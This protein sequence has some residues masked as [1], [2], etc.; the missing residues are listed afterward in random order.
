MLIFAKIA[1][2]V[3]ATVTSLMGIWQVAT[4]LELQPYLTLPSTLTYLNVFGLG[5]SNPSFGIE[6]IGNVSSELCLISMEDTDDNQ[7]IA[8]FG[9]GG[10]VP[11]SVIVEDPSSVASA[12]SHLCPPFD[13]PQILWAQSC[14][15]QDDPSCKNVGPGFDEETAYYGQLVLEKLASFNTIFDYLFS[16]VEERPTS[17]VEALQFSLVTVL[18]V[19]FVSVVGTAV[20]WSLRFVDLRGQKAPKTTESLPNVAEIALPGPKVEGND[21][22]S[23]VRDTVQSLSK[24]IPVPEEKYFDQLTLEML[25]FATEIAQARSDLVKEGFGQ[26][27]GRLSEQHNEVESKLH[28]EISKFME[29]NMSRFGPVSKHYK[30]LEEKLRAQF[31][32]AI[33]GNN[34]QVANV[35]KELD[36][37]FQSK[38][39]SK[40]NNESVSKLDIKLSK[41]MADTRTG[42]QLELK[43]AIKK[44][45]HDRVQALAKV[46]TSVSS[47]DT[48]ISEVLKNLKELNSSFKTLEQD[49]AKQRQENADLVRRIEEQ[50][51]A[52]Q[53]QTLR[54]AKELK[55]LESVLLGRADAGCKVLEGKLNNVEVDFQAKLGTVET[56]LE[57]TKNKFESKT[58]DIDA[59]I[60][61]QREDLE[62]VQEE[63]ESQAAN[64]S[65][66]KKLANS[67]V[68]SKDFQELENKFSGYVKIHQMNIFSDKIGKISY[69][70]ESKASIS[71]LQD[72]RGAMDRKFAK[73]DG[74]VV[75]V[76]QA[77]GSKAE[78]SEVD[79]LKLQ[80]ADKVD[81][82]KWAAS[83]KQD[84]AELATRSDRLQRQVD[85]LKGHLSAKVAVDDFDKLK[86]AVESAP[87]DLKSVANELPTKVA[88]EDFGGLKTAVEIAQSDPRSL[89]EKLSAKAETEYL[90]DL[91]DLMVKVQSGLT[92]AERKLPVI[93][94]MD[95][96]KIKETADFIKQ[97]TGKIRGLVND[98]VDHQEFDKLASKV[99][100]MAEKSLITEVQ[101]RI[102]EN[103]AEVSANCKEAQSMAT[104]AHTYNQP[105]AAEVAGLRSALQ[106][107]NIGDKANLEPHAGHGSE[108]S[109]VTTG[110]KMTPACRSP[111]SASPFAS[112]PPKASTPVTASVPGQQEQTVTPISAQASPTVAEG[113]AQPAQD[114]VSAPLASEPPVKRVSQPADGK[115]IAS[116]RLSNLHEPAV[117][118][119]P[120]A[121]AKGAAAMRQSRFA[122]PQR[123]ALADVTNVPCPT[124]SEG[125]KAVNPSDPALSSSSGETSSNSLKESRWA[126][127]RRT[128]RPPQSSGSHRQMGPAPQVPVPPPSADLGASRWAPQNVQRPGPA[129]DS[130]SKWQDRR[131]TEKT[132]PQQPQEP[133]PLASPAKTSGAL[134]KFNWEDVPEF[135][136]SSATTYPSP[137]LETSGWANQSKSA[138]PPRGPATL[139]P[140][141]PAV[142]APPQTPT[143]I[144]VSGANDVVVGMAQIPTQPKAMG[145]ASSGPSTPKEPKVLK[146]PQGQGP[147]P[148][149]GQRRQTANTKEHNVRR[150]TVWHIRK[151]LGRFT[152]EQQE[153]ARYHQDPE[154]LLF[155]KGSEWDW[156]NGVVTHH[157]PNFQVFPPP[158]WSAPVGPS[159]APPAL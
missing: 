101:K 47:H 19:G 25:T 156:L 112:N 21:V 5:L 109:T 90:D 11:E 111:S 126:Q 143:S 7:A 61:K 129:T 34:N 110:T 2:A 151:A 75:N 138:I 136:P 32:K 139:P 127:P 92:P 64:V 57:S 91:K 59:R 77:L 102:E 95:F 159:P 94:G 153:H 140:A 120:V 76:Q 135:S 113:A 142:N 66:A 93:K 148:D 83:E 150:R 53:S 128:P 97:Q 125:S 29:E 23:F 73:L 12:N 115:S 85:A 80:V 158:G 119:D 31:S 118:I 96:S 1:M 42:A 58:L 6:K 69:L 62:E 124:P 50:E 27:I 107:V 24:K 33:K 43:A 86:A 152:S 18:I 82:T 155:M 72:V 146:Y 67:K 141:N 8:T 3:A 71:A 38:L 134:T 54:T 98:R 89:E 87:S 41:V 114:S 35:K 49:H 4:V 28:A 9:S 22:I 45:D 99:E 84:K 117:R 17:A 13:I 131:P 145:G 68:D 123:P 144:D 16:F 26:E 51:R 132:A 103:I 60:G 106:G 48:S 74:D 104:S 37:S 154:T 122:P 149:G 52:Q 20:Y 105:T 39:N 116:Q 130:S 55:T 36:S 121:A 100:N 10:N 88:V 133:A 79:T 137:G 65:K 14:S 40:A 157:L 70:V 44:S 147:G 81:E 78:A 15:S 108:A 46:E 63:V 56:S 30:E